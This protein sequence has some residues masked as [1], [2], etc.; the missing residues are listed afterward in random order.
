MQFNRNPVSRKREIYTSHCRFTIPRIEITNMNI[1]QAVEA[2][3]TTKDTIDLSGS[4]GNADG[5][6][7]GTISS[8]YRRV[9]SYRSW[10]EV[11]LYSLFD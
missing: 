10:A 6:G 7:S 8:I 2:P 3:L 5:V 4:I 9:L 1:S 11:V